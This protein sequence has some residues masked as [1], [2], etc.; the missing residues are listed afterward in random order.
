MRVLC[1]FEALYVL[2]V[3]HAIFI[4]DGNLS[5]FKSPLLIDY[6]TQQHSEW[7]GQAEV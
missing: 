5:I 2:D 1:R 6:F 3:V 4:N 7:V